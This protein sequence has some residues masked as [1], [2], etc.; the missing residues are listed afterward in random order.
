MERGL[1]FFRAHTRCGHQLVGGDALVGIRLDQRLCD[2]QQLA[3]V[4]N[5]YT[6]PSEPGARLLYR[7]HL[8]RR[9]KYLDPVLLPGQQ[10]RL[11]QPGQRGP[12]PGVVG[13]GIPLECPVFVLG[14][15]LTGRGNH[16]TTQALLSVQV[17]QGPQDAVDLPP[18]QPR[19]GRHAELALHVVHGVEK[20][21]SCR[22]LVPPGAARLLQVVL[23]G[24]GDV[25]M[26]DKP[27]V[28][29]VYAHAKGIGGDDDPQVAAYEALLDILLGLRLQPRMEVAGLDSLVPQ[30]LR[31]FFSVP[32][33]C[34]VDDGAARTIDRQIGLYDLVN[35]IELLT[36][37]RLHCNEIQIL[38]TYSAVEDLQLDV[39]LLTKVG[40]DLLLDVRLGSCGQ[41]QHRRHRLVTRPLTDEAPHVAVVGPEVVP[42]FREAVGLVQDPGANLPLRQDTANRDA[43]KLLRRDDQDAGFPKPHAVQSIGTLRH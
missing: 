23:K 2:A 21:T 17:P 26:D 4:A 40:L 32:P 12:E 19:T 37:A 8:E 29:L 9:R 35:V 18:R 3:A 20:H 6:G 22:P 43:A 10:H 33:R 31:Y 5:R 34:A 41:A 38:A 30:E 27:H 25:G 24:T 7:A 42:P 13:S 11:L 16:L 14:E 15:D 1:D 28:R 39:Q 36:A